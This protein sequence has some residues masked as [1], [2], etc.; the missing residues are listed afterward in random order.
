MENNEMFSGQN[1]V[2]VNFVKTDDI[3]PDILQTVSGKSLQ[4]QD[5]QKKNTN[6]E[7]F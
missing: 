4:Q 7:D 3:L 5:K 6:R 2:M 1:S